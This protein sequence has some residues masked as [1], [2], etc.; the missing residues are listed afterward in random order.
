MIKNLIKFT[1]R[2]LGYR[3]EGVSH[4]ARQLRDVKSLRSVE[5]DDLV[6][7]RMFERGGALSFIQV[8][9]F[10]GI[11]KDPLRRYVQSCGWRGIMI[12]PQPSAAAKLRHLYAGNPSV[13]IVEAAI[14]RQQGTRLLYTVDAPDAPDWC[15][16]L[17]SFD[18]ETIVKHRALVPGLEKMIREQQVATMPFDAILARLPTRDIDILQLDT[19][20][21]DA[22][23]LA[24]FPFETVRPAIVH[25]EVKHLTLAERESAFERMLGWGYR[26][27]PSG[28]EDML[29]VLF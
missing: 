22:I 11:I 18:R 2:R 26:L 13:E 10:D 16:G 9:C 7:R 23:V 20:G 8:G 28:D 6:C 21:W 4:V 17:A 19:E 14:D 5:F 15:G 29:A 3:I 12:E 27:A 24:L 25:W 1:V